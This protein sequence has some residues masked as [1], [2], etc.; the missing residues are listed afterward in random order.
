VENSLKQRLIGAMVIVGLAVIFVPAILD[1]NDDKSLAVTMVAPERPDLQ[2]PFDVKSQ[3][4]DKEDAF[5][6]KTI[7]TPDE[8]IVSSND[9]SNKTGSEVKELIS[10]GKNLD[11]A[12]ETKD[13]KI[14]IVKK[15]PLA[16]KDTIP[17]QESQPKEVS[18]PKP[19]TKPAV[20]A[21]KPNGNWVV[22]LG[23]FSKKENAE[24]LKAKIEK[25]YKSVYI[26]TVKIASG[27]TYRLRLGNF[28]DKETAIIKRREV[29][30]A[31]NIAGVV[32]AK[33]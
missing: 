9:L 16:N 1:R 33:S 22:Q 19:V 21:N 26:D 13:T 15:V 11:E 7:Q 18:K 31:F 23:S 12:V 14:N 17:K 32:M 24:K 28:V 3:L 2:Q 5:D 8:L 30:Q 6:A 27:N 4:K 10:S 29:K 20:V 25:K